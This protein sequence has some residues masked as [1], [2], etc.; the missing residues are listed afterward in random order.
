MKQAVPSSLT[1]PR[2]SR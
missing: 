2:D 1:R